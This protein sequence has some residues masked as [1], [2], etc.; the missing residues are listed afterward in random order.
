VIVEYIR[1]K[2]A[3]DQRANFEQAYEQAQA[4]L[5]ASAHC[6][7]Y[8]LTHCVEQPEHYIVRIL[9]DS[10]EGHTEGFRRS[11]EFTTFFASVQPFFH[12]IEEM[13]HYQMMQ[14]VH[15]KTKER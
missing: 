4:A 10:M 5:L 11:P 3:A 8:E 9:W 2:V 14:E 13:Q 12:S 7:G 15:P 1:Y 6:E